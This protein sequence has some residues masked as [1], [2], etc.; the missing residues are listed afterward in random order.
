MCLNNNLVTFSLHQSATLAAQ[1]QEGNLF[2]CKVC[3]E[4]NLIYDIKPNNIFSCVSM[5]VEENRRK[6]RVAFQKA[7]VRAPFFLEGAN[8]FLAKGQK[9]IAAFMLHQAA[10]LTLRAIIYALTGKEVRSHSL[11][12]L[13]K[14]CKRVAPKLYLILSSCSDEQISKIQNAYLGARYQENFSISVDQVRYMSNVI[15]RLQEEALL[16]I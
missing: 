10:E 16:Q 4:E 1:I 8:D 6:A 2:Y 12:E 13:L 11:I 3:T 15:A 5:K 7:F 9:E 14:N